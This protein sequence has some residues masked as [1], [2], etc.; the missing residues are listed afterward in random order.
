MDLKHL[1]PELIG[2]VSEFADKSVACIVASTKS[3]AAD[4]SAAFTMLCL[5]RDLVH[6]KAEQPTI[7]NTYKYGLQECREA[8][9]K[10]YD[11]GTYVLSKPTGTASKDRKTAGQ[12]GAARMLTYAKHLALLSWAVTND[13]SLALDSVAETKSGLS[14]MADRSRLLEVA[15]DRAVLVPSK[16]KVKMV[17]LGGMEWDLEFV[18]SLKDEEK[19]LIGFTDSSDTINRELGASYK[20]LQHQMALA[21]LRNR[22]NS[23]TISRWR[24]ELGLPEVSGNA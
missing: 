1:T 17:T 5:M 15:F 19:A 22:H 2:V 24:K 11:E 12:A 18:E 14:T 8:A 20:R 16:T 3:K 6:I 10:A 13:Y 23:G 9:V 4:A 21:K 7:L